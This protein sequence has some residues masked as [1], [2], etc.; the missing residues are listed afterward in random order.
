MEIAI[1]H[2]F[3]NVKAQVAADFVEITDIFDPYFEGEFISAVG[4]EGLKF[5]VGCWIAGQAVDPIGGGHHGLANEPRIAVVK[6]EDLD[7]QA[8]RLIFPTR[9]VCDNIRQKI[10]V[11]HDLFH[12]FDRTQD[13]GADA[14]ILNNAKFI[15]HANDVAVTD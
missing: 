13:G 8:D 15:F 12:I 10:E 11:G 9:I 7:F 3:P 4:A 5:H 2:L 6:D 1:A 14:Y